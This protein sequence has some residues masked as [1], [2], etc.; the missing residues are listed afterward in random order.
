ML[1][2]SIVAVSDEK[3]VSTF[4]E[5]AL[6]NPALM[7]LGIKFG[8]NSAGCLFKQKWQNCMDQS[9]KGGSKKREG[10][11]TGKSHMLK[12]AFIHR[13]RMLG[14]QTCNFGLHQYSPL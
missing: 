3:P 10:K 14:E 7:R 2:F 12:I 9:S 13:C 1:N 6:F 4:S 8:D 11:F 5:T